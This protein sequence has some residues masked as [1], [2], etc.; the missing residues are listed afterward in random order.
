MSPSLFRLLT[1]LNRGI[2]KLKNKSEQLGDVDAQHLSDLRER[3]VQA[4][5]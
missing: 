4:F 3:A 5:R 2:V 1:N